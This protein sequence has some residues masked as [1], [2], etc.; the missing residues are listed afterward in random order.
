MQLSRDD[1]G[2]ENKF[3]SIGSVSIN[4]STVVLCK[5]YTLWGISGLRSDCWLWLHKIFSPYNGSIH[6]N[7]LIVEI[8][9]TY[10]AIFTII[11]VFLLSRITTEWIF[12]IGNRRDFFFL[13]Y[14]VPWHGNQGE[15]QAWQQQLYYFS[16]CLDTQKVEPCFFH[17]E[18]SGESLLTAV[19]NGVKTG[20]LSH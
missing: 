5:S 19:R 3:Q 7:S 4:Y 6:K 15:H 12:C 2:I 13:E 20:F 10:T 11:T 9:P 1:K 14:R 18:E 17:S 8:V 16:I